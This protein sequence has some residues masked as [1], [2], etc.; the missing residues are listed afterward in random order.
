[1]SDT[2][3]TLGG[4][5]DAA[6]T[7]P[8]E[9]DPTARLRGLHQVKRTLTAA[10][11]DDG[12][13][14]W[15][16]RWLERTCRPVLIAAH[17]D[18]GREGLLAAA[19]A[20]NGVDGVLWTE[21]L[22]PVRE[23][24]AALA[25]ALEDVDYAP[26]KLIPLGELVEWEELPE[27]EPSPGERRGRRRRR[28]APKAAKK[29]LAPPPPPPP[30]RIPFG[31]P[32]GTGKPL[33]TLRS[34]TPALLAALEAVGIVRISELVLRI[35]EDH[36]LIEPLAADSELPPD[37]QE[38]ALTGTI[39]ARWLRFGPAGRVA[40]ADFQVGE[41]LV[42]CRWAVGGEPLGSEPV[43]LVGRLERVDDQAVFYD[44]QRWHVGTRGAVRRPVYGIEGVEDADMHRLVREALSTHADRIQDPLPRPL[45]KD[46]RLLEFSDA[47]WELHVPRSGAAKGRERWAFE[48]LLYYQLALASTQQVRHRGMGHKVTHGLLTRLQQNQG[49]TLNDTQEMVFDEIRRDLRKATAMTRL[50]QGD[51]GSGKAI[52][53]LM[54]GLLV[55]EG[56]S[57]VCF[58]APD[59]ISATHRYLFAEP[60]LRTLGIVPM[61]ITGKPTSAQVDALRRGEATCVFATHRLAT[62]GLPDFKKLGLVIIEERD[63]FGVLDR[64]A[65]EQKGVQPDLLVV[66]SV[67]IPASLAFTVFSDHDIS[68]LH[69]SERQLVQARVRTPDGRE[70]AYAE[71]RERLDNGRQGYVCFPLLDGRD[72]L[73][74][75]RAKQLV[76]ALS[77]E[78]FPGFR[79]A[80]YHG[81]MS[82]DE[83]LRVFEDFQHRRIDVLVA[84]TTIE[85]APEV[86]NAT[87]M[88]VENA[89]RYDL[90]RLHRL[91]GH[92][93]QG[94][95]PGVC[96]FVFSSKPT[97]DGR[98]L[99]ELLAREQDGFAVAE[100]DRLAR[101]DAA[102]LGS[103]TADLPKFE[104]ADTA[105]D[106]V[107]LLRARKAALAILVQDPELRQRVH[108]SLAKRL[109]ELHPG[110][111][112]AELPPE[113]KKGRRRR[114]RRKRS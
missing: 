69:D 108:R 61:L 92:V 58:L 105:R 5:D 7:P 95:E 50:L 106:R 35:P 42:R 72:L 9:V 48:E 64:K 68:V 54:T 66:T 110:L 102:L 22:G 15:D 78:A 32:N 103:R 76:G 98:R 65:L 49:I 39:K 86:A 37:D 93:A 14:L 57:Q 33:S 81:A 109:R 19:D 84:T 41:A 2:Q 71:I 43:T 101:G 17:A 27:E 85:D 83:R 56:K 52:V 45:V 12:A 53:A 77:A 51:V 18:S 113:P 29:E 67:P 100:Q 114:R 23:A 94:R 16:F 80:L 4:S 75:D 8:V 79:V 6:A 20:L 26:L 47:L 38:L 1:M 104:V 112:S 74:L 30:P 107:L 91:R 44:P 90:V 62:G 99:V 63:H 3:V 25:G 111:L 36:V 31:A 60:T 24:V 70:E 13:R 40:E 34:A 46:A 89:D 73:P 97:D 10:V 82:R 96:N 21:R 28:G 87:A 88:H 55:A 59:D 11:A